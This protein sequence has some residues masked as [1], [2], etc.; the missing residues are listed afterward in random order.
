MKG[1]GNDVGL[2]MYLSF[3][4]PGHS[5]PKQW[6]RRHVHHPNYL[7][8]HLPIPLHTKLSTYLPTSLVASIYLPIYLIYLICL[9]V[10]NSGIWR[11]G[12]EAP[13]S[14]RCGNKF[15]MARAVPVSSHEL[16]QMEFGSTCGMTARTKQ[17]TSMRYTYPTVTLAHVLRPED[18]EDDV[19]R[20]KLTR[21]SRQ[22]RTVQRNMTFEA[23][24]ISYISVKRKLHKRRRVSCGASKLM[25]SDDTQHSRGSVPKPVNTKWNWCVHVCVYVCVVCVLRAARKISRRS[26]FVGTDSWN[27]WNHLVRIFIGRGVHGATLSN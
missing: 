26:I 7:P 8:T 3:K 10:C 9:R 20:L 1:S 15:K 27:S 25:P 4:E 12:C 24:Q 23:S 2:I 5:E 22:Q 17:R 19:R 16:W 11:T 18:Y 14:N 6:K 13:S 21:Y